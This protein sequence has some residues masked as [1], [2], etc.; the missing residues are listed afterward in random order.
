MK[1]FKKIII[2]FLLLIVMT[3]TSCW[4]FKDLNTMGLLVGMGIDKT[5]DDMFEVTFQIARPYIVKAI[6]EGS[7]DEAFWTFTSKGKT[8]FDAIR[9]ALSTADKKIYFAHVQI[10]II[11]EKLA[12]EGIKDIFDVFERGF[13]LYSSSCLQTK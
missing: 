8:L 12:K 9:N 3:L 1:K 6:S 11:G 7:P 10:I 5:D 2:I 4:N 13:E